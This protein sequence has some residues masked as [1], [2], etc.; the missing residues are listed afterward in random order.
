MI[1][2]Q[3]PDQ[4]W[5]MQNFVS[6]MIGG[7]LPFGAVFIELFFI[8]SSVW[9]NQA[10]AIRIAGILEGTNSLVGPQFYYVFGFLALVVFILII[11]CSEI[12]IVLVYFQLCSEVRVL[13][14]DCAKCSAGGLVQTGSLSTCT[15]AQDYNWWW[16]SFFGSGSSGLYLFMYGILYFKTKVRNNGM[17]NLAS[18]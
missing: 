6:V 12:S 13:D 18:Q 16:R 3:I 5:Y 15:T 14:H 9:L 4:A 11:T 17:H 2:R 1:P 7:I 8:L 10:R